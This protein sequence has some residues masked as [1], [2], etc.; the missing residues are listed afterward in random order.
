MMI[1]FTF[2][3]YISGKLEGKIEVTGKQG[4][5]YKQLLDYLNEKRGCWELKEETSDRT[6]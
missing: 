1:V 4:R 2:L 6:V 3:Q 5:R